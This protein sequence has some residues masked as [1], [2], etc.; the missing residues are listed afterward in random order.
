MTNN[1]FQIANLKELRWDDNFFQIANL[2][3]L[4]V[5]SIKARQDSIKARQDL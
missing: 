1:I 2:K 5:D 3:E 4:W